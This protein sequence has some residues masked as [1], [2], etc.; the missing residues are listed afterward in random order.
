MREPTNVEKIENRILNLRGRRVMLDFDLAELCGVETKQLT[1]QVRRNLRRFPDD[2]M[3]Q[4]TQKELANLRCQIGTS[5]WGGR[6]H[7][8]YAFTEQG[9]A[10]LSSVLNSERAILVMFK[11][12]GRLLS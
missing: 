2:F 10:M 4:L 12:C 8:P 6:R 11:S 5:R 1:R 3:H 7:L 9:I